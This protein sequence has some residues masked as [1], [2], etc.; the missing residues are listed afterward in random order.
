[1]ALRRISSDSRFLYLRSFFLLVALRKTSRRQ[2]LMCCYLSWNADR[3]S[4]A[5]VVIRAHIIGGARSHRHRIAISPPNLSSHSNYAA[6][7]SAQRCLAQK[8]R[9]P[10]SDAAASFLF[11]I[12]PSLLELIIALSSS[13]IRFQLASV[14]TI[15]CG[16]MGDIDAA[17]YHVAQYR[18]LAKSAVSAGTFF[19]AAACA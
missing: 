2:Q 6:P 9:L 8:L 11:C 10:I 14:P 19:L 12:S 4:R 13:A 16:D 1:M 18:Y 5:D 3:G 15:N 7:S 17:P